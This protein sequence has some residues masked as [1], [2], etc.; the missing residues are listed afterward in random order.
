MIKSA[1]VRASVVV[2]LLGMQ[3]DPAIAQA[4]A[5]G[6]SSSETTDSDCLLDR[7]DFHPYYT[8]DYSMNR[9]S[10]TWGQALSMT[11]KVGPFD[12]NNRWMVMKGKDPNRSSLRQKRGAM[13]VGLGYDLPHYGSWTIGLD[14]KF[15]RD[16]QL[17]S[18]RDVIDNNSDYGVVV[19]TGLP[20]Q[21]MQRFVL[22]LREFALKTD[23]NFG[24]SLGDNVSR[25]S[26]RGAT[27]IDSTQVDGRSP[28]ERCL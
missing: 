16:S 18:F 15:R 23:V 11:R 13:S 10:R 1:I 8:T 20:E 5:G 25:R 17:A 7:I 26:I 21:V 6:S 19:K 12:F 3:M 2:C 24:Y 9:S 28:T 27:L 14:G 4:A 22:P